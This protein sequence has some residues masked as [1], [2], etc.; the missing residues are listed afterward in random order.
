MIGFNCGVEILA[1][2]MLCVALEKDFSIGQS[3]LGHSQLTQ[4]RL[5]PNGKDHDYCERS[6]LRTDGIHSGAVMDA[7]KYRPPS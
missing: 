4:Q 6:E 2:A 5:S 1:G 3:R 7:K